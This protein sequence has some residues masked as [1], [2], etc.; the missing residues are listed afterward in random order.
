MG[1]T[2]YD[3][4]SFSLKI[5]D[6]WQLD[7][8]SSE[9]LKNE[10]QRI[11]L[12]II[13]ENKQIKNITNMYRPINGFSVKI[14]QNLSESTVKTFEDIKTKKNIEIVRQS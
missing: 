7:K 6:G 5:L 12:N 2:K 14:K 8:F 13:Y 3:I 4:L 11:K 1:I 9:Y 10:I